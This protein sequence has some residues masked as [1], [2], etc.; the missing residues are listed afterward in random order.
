MFHT[1]KRWLGRGFLNHQPIWLFSKSI[2]LCRHLTGG[3]TTSSTKGPGEWVDSHIFLIENDGFSSQWVQTHRKRM[4]MNYQAQVVSLPD[5][6]TINS[7]FSLIPEGLLGFL[8]TWNSAQ[9]AFTAM[10]AAQWI[11]GELGTLQDGER[12]CRRVDL[13]GGLDIPYRMYVTGIFTS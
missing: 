13:F 1:S 4:G 6:W 3:L 11:G 2:I 10:D 9:E 5:F 8:L 12:Q 7:M